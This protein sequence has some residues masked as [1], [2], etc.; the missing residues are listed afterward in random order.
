VNKGSVTLVVEG[1]HDER[2]FVAG[3]RPI[4]SDERSRVAVIDM[5]CMSKL[6]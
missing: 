5:G 1:K 6:L 4:R 2:G 3:R